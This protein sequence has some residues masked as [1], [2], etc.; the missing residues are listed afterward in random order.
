MADLKHLKVQPHGETG[1][2]DPLA[3]L[4]RIMGMTM[5][6]GARD[7]ASDEFGIDL[8][9]ELIG[10][11][12]ANDS[13][14][15]AAVAARSGPP[16]RSFVPRSPENQ[17]TGSRSNGSQANG[18]QSSAPQ[19]RGPQSNGSESTESWKAAFREA[20]PVLREPSAAGPSRGPGD[21]VA[22]ISQ[23]VSQQPGQ[24]VAHSAGSPAEPSALRHDW[25]PA[26]APEP[27]VLRPAV[28]V[29]PP[30][31]AETP[32]EDPFERLAAFSRQWLD[33][34]QPDALPGANGGAGGSFRMPVLPAGPVSPVPAA[35]RPK[36]VADHAPRPA[37]ASPAPSSPGHAFPASSGA[38]PV[39]SGKDR[40]SAAADGPV[41]SAAPAR[42]AEPEPVASPPSEDK[43]FDPFAELVAMAGHSRPAAAAPSALAAVPAADRAAAAGPAAPHWDAPAVPL[44]SGPRATPAAG[45]SSDAGPQN[46]SAVANP[47]IIARRT[48]WQSVS[49][50]ASAIVPRDAAP[51]DGAPRDTLPRG[52]APRDAMSAVPVMA[53]V[54]PVASSRADVVSS[55]SPATVEPAPVAR[56]DVATPAEAVRPVTA[57][58]PVGTH[59]D[60]SEAPIRD[61]HAAVDRREL[62]VEPASDAEGAGDPT[63]DAISAWVSQPSERGVRSA[64]AEDQLHDDLDD[65]FFFASDAGNASVLPPVARIPELGPDVPA[66]DDFGDFGA[67]FDLESLLRNE[68]E[69]EGY[70]GGDAPVA[71][72]L[73]RLAAAAAALADRPAVE[74]VHA[75]APDEPSEGLRQT[76]AQPAAPAAGAGMDE[77]ADDRDETGMPEVDT[78]EVPTARYVVADEI[79]VPELAVEDE[80]Q[81][82]AAVDDIDADFGGGFEDRAETRPVAAIA[83]APA[84]QA[85]AWQTASPQP[86]GSASGQDQRIGDLDTAFDDAVRSWAEAENEKD[87]IA[88][89]AAGAATWANVR[90]DYRDDDDAGFSPEYPPA[91]PVRQESHPGHRNRGFVV[92]ALVA[93]VAVVGGIGAFMMSTGGGGGSDAPALVRAD[94]EPVKVKPE[95]PGGVTVP[96]QDKAVYERFTAG[97][98]TGQPAQE[99]LVSTQEEPVNLAV[100]TVP[101][102]APTPLTDP[103]DAA[104]ADELAASDELPAADGLPAAFGQPVD[105]ARPKSE[106]RIEP[107]DDIDAA[108][109][110][111]V[112][113]IAPR[114]V[115]TMVV[116]PDGRMVPREEVAPEALVVAA[117]DPAPD[118]IEPAPAEETS[119][120]QPPV[121]LAQAPIRTSEAAP[122]AES[123]VTGTIPAPAAGQEPPVRTVETRTITRDQATPT[124]GP[125]APTRP[126]D[127]PVDIVGN[128]GGAAPATQVAA[129][130]PAPAAT[131]QSS[132]WSMQIASQPTPEGAQASYAD[133]SRRYAAVLN[134]RGVNIVK[135]EIAGKGTYW[136]VRIPTSS[137]ADAN[138]LCE[139]F[140]AAGGSCFVSR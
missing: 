83:A 22:P 41:P 70:G 15:P 131:A 128:T 82:S 127:Q 100:R 32:E 52:A 98:E 92:A 89:V 76:Q 20:A 25:S 126:S 88:E 130:A 61:A 97:S 5:P 117:A 38:A 86:T 111:D 120:E 121:P 6:S 105:L 106:D 68:L 8:E 74:R 67:D 10:D 2:S 79:D 93:G 13:H 36:P 139:R 81:P 134:G 99:R 101:I 80:V 124:R 39:S 40:L 1:G 119:S 59:A 17:S 21:P 69:S 108:P 75:D 60:R 122:A 87:R 125:V 115:R 37:A 57:P 77:P 133:L 129:V 113:V 112:A 24:G 53:T 19:A 51:H 27:P 140:K 9:R 85:E 29:A 28:P 11:L 135:A 45:G 54:V 26:K 96:N 66:R 137:R 55:A 56:T 46:Q 47:S 58:E 18:P 4:T 73:G 33:R 136:R 23:S 84:A 44:R 12:G 71:D 123:G 62:P 118:A 72:D 48:N 109:S 49:G 16:A 43:V 104:A 50:G 114:R 34:R 116:L 14:A 91:P 78:V 35:E 95:Q 103:A 132:E 64:E 42:A 31:A 7:A 94:P 30:S 65:D 90:P 110:G 138:T 63:W 107:V 3:E 102:T